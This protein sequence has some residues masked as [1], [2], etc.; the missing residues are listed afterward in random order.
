[1][2]CGEVCRLGEEFFLSFFKGVWF[3]SLF[4]CLPF[5]GIPDNTPDKPYRLD[6]PSIIIF[7]S[8][9]L[10][11]PYRAETCRR[12]VVSLLPALRLQ[13]LA[14]SPACP[15]KRSFFSSLRC[16]KLSS[17][18]QQRGK[19]KPRVQCLFEQD[20]NAFGL[21][22]VASSL[23]D[24][25]REAWDEVVSETLDNADAEAHQNFRPRQGRQN[26]YSYYFF[27]APFSARSVDAVV[28]SGGG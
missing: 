17:E 10:S 25:G 11:T 28:G 20:C 21:E 2:I 12:E 1:M 18:R 5:L 27:L 3:L 16:R 26:Y 6:K 9:S 24:A 13:D 14:R 8:A 19:L 22:C 23:Q 4:P 15:S 7:Q